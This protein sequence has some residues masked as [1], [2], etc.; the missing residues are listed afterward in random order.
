MAST[1]YVG[2]SFD[3]LQT[4]KNTCKD[5]AIQH[6]FEYRVLKANKSRY[7]IECKA[8][9]C[10]WRLHASLV[11]GS[12]ICRIKTYESQ[13]TCFGINHSGHTQASH[14]FLA[15]KI[16]DK[17]R[18]QPS[19]HPVDIIRDVQR[20]MGIK[21]SYS[22]AYRT[23]ERANEINNGT[24]DAAYRSLPKYCQ[25]LVNSNVNSTAILEKTPE[26]KFHR[27]FIS[28][29]AAATGFKYCCPLLGLDGTHLKHKYQGTS[30]GHVT[31]SR[32]SSH[33]Y[34]R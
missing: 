6:A 19:Y 21:V 9:G 24:H 16:A 7:T 29:G 33:S 17:V 8:E 26:D 20:E 32:N 1:L 23:K 18:K 30:C 25:D 4:L 34:W 14:G 11:H 10:T 3:T 22:T 27:L 15:Q 31:K 2:A 12:S 28:Y 5:Y 13:H